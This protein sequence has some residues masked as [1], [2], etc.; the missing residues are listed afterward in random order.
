LILALEA[1][2]E[3]IGLNFVGGVLRENTANVR[4]R[5][6]GVGALNCLEGKGALQG[7][8]LGLVGLLEAEQ[9]AEHLVFVQR[10][11]VGFRDILLQHGQNLT[12]GCAVDV[13]EHDRPREG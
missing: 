7:P 13:G 4:C 3:S 1:G 2:E 5:S 12:V 10:P 8:L 11:R 6:R 9:I